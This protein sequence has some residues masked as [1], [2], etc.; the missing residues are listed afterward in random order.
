MGAQRR[1]RR[2]PSSSDRRAREVDRKPVEMAAPSIARNLDENG[3]AIR[4]RAHGRDDRMIALSLGRCKPFLTVLSCDCRVSLA[5][6]ADKLQV[7]SRPLCP[8]SDRPPSQGRMSRWANKDRLHCKKESRSTVAFL[9][10][11]TFGIISLL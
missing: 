6:G 9:S 7:Q 1:P 8:E 3:A 4:M 5:T 2:V 11:P 10:L